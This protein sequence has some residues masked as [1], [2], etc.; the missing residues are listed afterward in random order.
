[1]DLKKIME[2][3]NDFDKDHVGNFDWAIAITENNLEILEFLI[4]C[5]MGE[6]GE[7]SNT[8]K[9]VVR[10]DFHLDTKKEQI[11]EEITD[12]FIYV[13]K[14]CNQLNID[15]EANFIKKLEYNKERF[16]NYEK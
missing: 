6:L 13:V 10:G 8:V 12:I 16:K 14:L 2:V 11:E 7:L 5:I 15:L 3:Q 9:K 1:M 4:I